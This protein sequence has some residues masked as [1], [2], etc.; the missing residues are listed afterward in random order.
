M[1]MTL[2]D[3]SMLFLVQT[4]PV[5]LAAEKLAAEVQDLCEPKTDLAESDSDSRA[6]LKR[7]RV[8]GTGNQAVLR[9]CGTEIDKRACSPAIEC[10]RSAAVMRCG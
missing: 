6:G 2:A 1:T 7:D 5:E 3:K 4:I 9:G 8:H 10:M